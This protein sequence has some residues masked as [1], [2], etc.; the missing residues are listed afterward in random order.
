MKRNDSAD[1]VTCVR[2]LTSSRVACDTVCGYAWAVLAPTAPKY[3]MIAGSK[4][5]EI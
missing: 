3:G 5:S 2:A 1:A 4:A